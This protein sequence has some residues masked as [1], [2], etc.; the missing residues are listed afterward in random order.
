M[1][2]RRRK[3]RK[4]KGKGTD[5]RKRKQKRKRKRKRKGLMGT[6]RVGQHPPRIARNVLSPGQVLGNRVWHRVLQRLVVDG[7]L[8]PF[9]V[10]KV[11]PPFVVDGVLQ[12]LVVDG[13]FQW[14][15]VDGVLQRLVLRSHGVFWSHRVLQ[16]VVSLVCRVRVVTRVGWRLMFLP[17]RCLP[18]LASASAQNIHVS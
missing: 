13:V 6:T 1:E 3:G 5:L 15:A 8:P 2:M 11:L 4:G 12:Q 9:V 7:V 17:G 14:L 18:H 16:G 10:D